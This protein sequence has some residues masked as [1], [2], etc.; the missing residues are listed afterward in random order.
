[1][2]YVRT[3]IVTTLM[4][5]TGLVGYMVYTFDGD[6]QLNKALEAFQKEEYAQAQ[7]ILG[8]LDGTL[9]G[10]QLNLARAYITKAQG[11][12]ASSELYLDKAEAAVTRSQTELLDEIHVLK[13]H[14]AF[15]QNKPEE[16]EGLLAQQDSYNPIIRYLSGL[17]AY[18]RGEYESALN[19]LQSVPTLEQLNPW[20][21]RVLDDIVYAAPRHIRVAHCHMALGDPITARKLLEEDTERFDRDSL[22]DSWF[23]IGMSYLEEA[24]GRPLTAVTSYY[25]LALDYFDRVPVQYERFAK[26]RAEVIELLQDT[27]S[28]MLTQNELQQLPLVMEALGHWNA[29]SSVE[30][31]SN[32]LIEMTLAAIET[33]DFE[34]V[35]EMTKLFNRVA[36]EESHRQALSKAAQERLKMS[37]TQGEVE[38]ILPYWELNRTLAPN[39]QEV[40]ATFTDFA[41]KEILGAVA[42]DDPNLDFIV[43]Y[44]T[45]WDLV[46]RN[47]DQRFAFAATLIDTA[48]ALWLSEKFEVVK[49]LRL[50][51]LAEDLPYITEH[52]AIKEKAKKALQALYQDAL[53]RGVV[54]GLAALVEAASFYGLASSDLQD[55]A[56]LASQLADAE[57]LY[58]E[59]RYDDATIRLGLIMRVDPMSAKG[60]R[61]LGLIEFR[62]G[63][64]AEA[65]VSLKIVP[66]LDREGQEALA[67]CEVLEGDSALGTHLLNRL[68]ELKPIEIASAKRLAF[69]LLERRDPRGALARFNKMKE[70]DS[71]TWAAR[72]QIAYEG[73]EW[74]EV[75]RAYEELDE[76]YQAETALKMMVAQALGQLGRSKDAQKIFEGIFSSE[77]RSAALSP[78][79]EKLKTLYSREW[80]RHQLA[81]D[82]YRDTAP[83]AEKLIVHL[84]ALE[85]LSPDQQ[86]LRGKSYFAIGERAKGRADL[87]AVFS[88]LTKQGKVQASKELGLIM[89]DLG[90]Y[91]DASRF[92]ETYLTD[93][94]NDTEVHKKAADAAMSARRWDLALSSLSA[95]KESGELSD[96]HKV[97]LVSALVKKGTL[98]PLYPLL[99][100]WVGDASTLSLA[101]KLTIAAEAIPMR[102]DS[103][104][105][106]LMEGVA[107]QPLDV[108]EKMALLHYYLLRSDQANAEKLA[109]ELKE[110]L[111]T[112]VE[113]RKLL[114]L[115]E[116][117]SSQDDLAVVSAQ[118][119]A[120]GNRAAPAFTKF[121]MEKDIDSIW[122][123][124]RMNKQKGLLKREPNS[125][126]A[127]IAAARSTLYFALS[128]NREKTGTWSLFD[129]T[130]SEAKQLLEEV[131]ADS[132]HLPEAYE[133]MGRALTSLKAKEQAV[134]VLKK[135]S[136]LDPSSVS[137]VLNLSQI[138]VEQG[139]GEEARQLLEK[140]TQR[141]P[142]ESSVWFALATRY[143][144]EGELLQAKECY[145][146]LVALRPRDSEA[147]FGLGKLLLNLR[148]PEAAFEVLGKGIEIAPNSE[149]GLEL[150]ISC[151]HD[152]GFVRDSKDKALAEKQ[153]VAYESLY[154]LNP[155]KA[156]RARGRHQKSSVE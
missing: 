139:K 107:A 30:T 77:Q 75:A 115:W 4:L 43:P 156:D 22:V 151:L 152:E 15:E 32:R 5:I 59:G 40:A 70:S 123:E 141:H 45:L 82:F 39:E 88:D 34:R 51:Q 54:D 23:L 104:V 56:E 65:L 119:I 132:D 114:F 58:E 13:I 146:T 147:Y 93:Y 71:D 36:P 122:M 83:N 105:V 21:K 37:V 111:N 135:G 25:Q 92:F 136:D 8:E 116:Q 130:V 62:K 55:P 117:Q 94:S 2:I 12:L 148:N 142:Y 29:K 11:D 48:G 90:L 78:E 118:E 96:E 101:T 89:Y 99:A 103:L 31:L 109:S 102:E 61:L 144:K 44:L 63:S 86:A 38:R 137:I 121:I 19:S 60:R 106:D 145:Q 97:T 149:L 26:E 69:G 47:S 128:R 153:A 72:M 120:E 17:A 10:A 98:Q 131:L 46:E 7:R 125:I 124:K 113:G 3:A 112:S 24:K 80:D 108:P 35:R 53:D 28:T 73:S 67:I 85:T 155:K 66:K 76:N 129:E 143:E 95:L 16:M 52:K 127:K 81:I 110:T 41:E 126:A 133:L 64:M 18:S 150:M 14:N 154:R 1:M 68:E 42:G 84:N 50:F 74:G 27:A 91:A 6:Y 79:Y 9:N 134:D 100:S 49:S 20:Q 138:F 87:E 57:Y 140:A 33:A